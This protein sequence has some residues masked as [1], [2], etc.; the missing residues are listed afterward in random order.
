MNNPKSWQLMAVITGVASLIFLY[1]LSSFACKSLT[2]CPFGKYRAEAS[3]TDE[4]L[5]Q[6]VTEGLV[7]AYI[8]YSRAY[9]VN[10]QDMYEVGVDSSGKADIEFES[11]NS[12]PLHVS[13][14]REDKQTS[15]LF[16]FS[17]ESI[18]AN[19]TISQTKPERFIEGGFLEGGNDR[20]ML[21]L[22]IKDWSLF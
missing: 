21:K 3:F 5:K 16:V 20:I 15:T 1:S 11:V 12:Y 4:K 9:L 22:E 7:R 13:I 2:R 19:S 17:D 14:Y 18:E 6:P 10:N 8:D